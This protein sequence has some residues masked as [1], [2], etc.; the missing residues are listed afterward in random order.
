MNESIVYEGLDD[1][2]YRLGNCEANESETIPS[3]AL[4]VYSTYSLHL[5]T[6]LL[7]L[8][9]L[10]REAVRSAVRRRYGLNVERLSPG[11]SLSVA[12]EWTDAVTGGRPS[13]QTKIARIY[14]DTDRFVE[15]F[16]KLYAFF[17]CRETSWSL[18]RYR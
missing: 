15:D 1:L 3:T 13:V 14:S 5:W 18:G 10:K 8:F 12:A 11:K 6:Q 16:D 9:E 7:E 2:L 17:F 4:R